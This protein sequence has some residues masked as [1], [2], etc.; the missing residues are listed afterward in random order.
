M[1]KYFRQT[2]SMV[3]C[4]IL[5]TNA[6]SCSKSTNVLPEV[7]PREQNYVKT[8]YLMGNSA[9]LET[10]MRYKPTVSGDSLYISFKNLF[11]E[12][13]E[14]LKVL[15]EEHNGTGLYDESHITLN[16]N[17]EQLATGAISAEYVI[18]IK[19]EDGF[20]PEHFNI[21]VVGLKSHTTHYLSG[22]YTNRYS[23]L[24]DSLEQKQYL[25]LYAIIEVDGNT[26]MRIK[27]NSEQYWTLKEAIFEGDGTFLAPVFY[28]DEIVSFAQIVDSSSIYLK[29]NVLGLHC[30]L[31]S[32]LNLQYDKLILNL[33]KIY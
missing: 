17:L 14:A 9:F 30:A 32:P 25:Q 3:L 24:Q 21:Y 4:F 22:Q 12:D 26:V 31:S 33:N 15:V 28:Q 27:R 20:N 2:L 1:V 23:W 16:V 6:M 5:L 8:K 29:D 13:L 10:H 11:S 18:P 19:G 7:R